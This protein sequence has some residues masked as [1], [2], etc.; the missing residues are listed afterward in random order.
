[1]EEGSVVA[2]G[3]LIFIAHGF[4]KH[5]SLSL[6]MIVL[7]CRWGAWLCGFRMVLHVASRPGLWMFGIA[8]ANESVL[9]RFASEYFVQKCRNRFFNAALVTTM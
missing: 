8:V 4:A 3:D 5:W 1:L 6:L 9:L 7:S 2:F